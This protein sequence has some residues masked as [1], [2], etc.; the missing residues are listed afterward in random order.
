[1]GGFRQR[2]RDYLRGLSSHCPKELLLYQVMEESG[3][4]FL[5]YAGGVLDQPAVLWERLM[6]CQ[7]EVAAYRKE[8]QAQ[9]ER[10]QT[11]Q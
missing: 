1:V 5:P 2:A 6:I 3:W 4:K 9:E 10:K 7:H 11:D 8:K